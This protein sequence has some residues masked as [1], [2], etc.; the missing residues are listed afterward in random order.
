MVNNGYPEVGKLLEQEV[1]AGE[2]NRGTQRMCMQPERVH[3]GVSKS[4]A[5][6]MSTEKREKTDL[7]DDAAISTTATH[8]ASISL[9]MHVLCL[10]KVQHKKNI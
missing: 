10:P 5:G 1:E 9:P 6:P 8:L 4:P 3:K 2:A 7:E